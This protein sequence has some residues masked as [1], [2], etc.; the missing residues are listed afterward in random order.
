MTGRIPVE[1]ATRWQAGPAWHRHQ[2]VVWME[3]PDPHVLIQQVLPAPM[4]TLNSSLPYYIRVSQTP[5]GM[6]FDLLDTWGG[7]IVRDVEWRESRLWSQVIFQ[8][9]DQVNP[10]WFR[11]RVPD[12]EHNLMTRIWDTIEAIDARPDDPFMVRQEI[13]QLRRE[14]VLD[15]IGAPVFRTDAR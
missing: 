14:M 12:A 13:A 6:R 3:R 8:P 11:W 4:F 7:P 10:W 9:Y 1:M 2:G 5:S 15:R